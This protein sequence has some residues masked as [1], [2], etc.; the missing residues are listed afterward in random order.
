MIVAD[1]NLLAYL[2]IPGGKTSLAE[3]VFL[4]DHE[5][6]AP[7]ICRSEMQNIVAVYMRHE[8]MSLA[9]GIGVMEH[10]D[11]IWERRLYALPSADVLQIAATG[12][13]SAY[14]AEFVVL[15]QQLQIPLVTYDKAIQKAFPSTALSAESFL[16]S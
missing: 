16:L 14:D 3:Q 10:A 7:F 8:G 1:F 4:K 15:A 6:A 12:N 9:Q 11:K 13:L 5:W 2:L